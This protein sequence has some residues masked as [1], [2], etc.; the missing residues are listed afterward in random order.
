MVGRP[1]SSH[2]PDKHGFTS[3]RSPARGQDYPGNELLRTHR[4]VL[5]ELQFADVAELSA[6]HQEPEVRETLL[7]P[8]PIAFLEVAGL[9]IQANRVYAQ[10][11]GL[12]IWRAADHSG[13]FVGLFSLMPV[14]DSE[15]VELGARLMPQMFGRL[16]SLEGARALRDHAF[17]NLGLPR[18]YGFCHPQNHAVPAI[19]RRLGFEAA[20]QAQHFGK[21]ALKFILE[22]P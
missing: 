22:H 16:Y 18:L 14:G 1:T 8:V 2:D 15:D 12:G 10:R 11:P 20:G 4:L 21:D 3:A 5:R 17:A 13:Q 19:F 6:L 7:E 9:V